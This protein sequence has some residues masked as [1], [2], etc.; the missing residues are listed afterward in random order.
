MLMKSVMSKG[1]ARRIRVLLDDQSGVT[2]MEYG[3]IAAATVVAISA[4]MPGITSRLSDIFSSVS[5]AL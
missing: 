2:A 1:I 5:N 4:F 3:L